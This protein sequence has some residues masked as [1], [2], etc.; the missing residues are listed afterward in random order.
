LNNINNI[1]SPC[2]SQNQ[3]LQY[4]DNN[5]DNASKRICEEHFTNCELCSD[6]IDALYYLSPQARKDLMN[7]D[8]K[9]DAQAL[10]VSYKRNKTWQI[11]ASLLLLFGLGATTFYMLQPRHAQEITLAKNESIVSDSI[12]LNSNKPKLSAS[13][14]LAAEETII[15][16]DIAPVEE[17]TKNTE[18]EKNTDNSVIAKHES[19]LSNET[20]VIDAK[21]IEKMITTNSEND[22]AVNPAPISNTAATVIDNQANKPSVAIGGGRAENT[23][24]IKD[25]VVA[26]KSL[27]KLS[28]KEERKKVQT[29]SAKD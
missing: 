19:P 27:K 5:L 23:I 24:Y 6:A 17:K 8:H 12:E 11:A 21:K 2:L 16:K 22:L 28:T 20:P 1:Q 15:K 3:L 10:N 14:T 26:N 13:K 7:F 29:E 25:G 18:S 9:Q 4:L